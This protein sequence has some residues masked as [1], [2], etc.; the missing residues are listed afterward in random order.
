MDLRAEAG[1][2]VRQEIIV[3]QAS[4]VRSV[5]ATDNQAIVRVLGA[6]TGDVVEEVTE[7]IEGSTSDVLTGDASF[8]TVHQDGGELE[9]I[10]LSELDGCLSFVVGFEVLG[11]LVLFAWEILVII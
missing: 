4:L 8:P 1:E 9:P 7:A 5:V 2:D 3:I 10:G 11:L 6:T